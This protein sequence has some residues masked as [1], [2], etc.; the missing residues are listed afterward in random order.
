[1]AK[2][3]LKLSNLSKFY[4]G[5]Q[6]VVVG[7]NEVNLSFSRGEFVA[8]TGESGSGKSTLSHV[9][10]GILP[11]ESGEMFFAG[12]PTS[13]YDSADWEAYRRDNISFISQNYGILPGATVMENVVSALLLTGMEKLEAHTAVEA[14][15][16]QVEL[17]DLHKRRAAKLSSGQ[18]QRLSIARALAKPAPILIA[19]EPTGNLDPENSAKVIDLLTQAAQE[20]LVILVTHEFSEAEHCATRHIILQDGKV[21][22]DAPLGSPYE[23]EAFVRRPK[24]KKPVSHYVAR[25]QQRSRPVWSSFLA[26]FF[27]LTAFAV[28]AFLGTLIV[29]LDD[30]STRPYDNSIFKNGDEDRI[31]V[32]RQ[33]G[34]PL[35]E[36][37]YAALL[38]VS[39]VQQL[40]VYGYVTDHQYAYREGV[41]YDIIT[42]EE[43]RTDANQNEI[44][45]LYPSPKMRSSAPFMKTIP[46][47]PEGQTFLTAGRLPENMYEVVA[48]GDE[49][50]IGQE[51]TVYLSNTTYMPSDVY[52]EIKMTVVGVTDLEDGLYFHEDIGRV[53]MQIRL[54][55]TG[56]KGKSGWCFLPNSAVP[57]GEYLGPSTLI[58]EMNLK[59]FDNLKR[60]SKIAGL[61]PETI[62]GQWKFYNF[63]AVNDDQAEEYISLRAMGNDSDVYFLTHLWNYQS[64]SLTTS[65]AYAP[66][67]R[68]QI[69]SNSTVKYGPQE[70]NCFTFYPLGDS[71]IAE[72]G[73]IQPGQYLILYWANDTDVWAV[74]AESV[75][76]AGIYGHK[77]VKLTMDENGVPSGYGDSQIWT[78][79]LVG[80]NV[81]T[82]RSNYSTVTYTEIDGQVHEI[83]ENLETYLSSGF[84]HPSHAQNEA[85]RYWT[86]D[87]QRNYKSDDDLLSGFV[88]VSQ[89]DFDRL[90]WDGGC[91]Q[92]SLTIADY[93]Y[94]DRVLNAIQEM[95]YVAASPYQLGSVKQDE[96]LAQQR[97]QTLLICIAA[98]AA[99]VALQVIL[100]RAMFLGQMDSYRLLSNIGLSFK[101]AK[102]S[103]LWQILL[104]CITGQLINIGALALCNHLAVERIVHILR[105][106]HPLAIV[107]LIAVHFAVSMAAAWWI[108][109][110]LRKQ[111][112]A[113]VAR[114]NDLPVEDT[115]QEAEL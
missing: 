62:G 74:S 59:H 88:W 11:Y 87:R 3:I 34:L 63:N 115:E 1:M 35:T 53:W 41:D 99:I 52:M 96:G 27:A 21:V 84:V 26:L 107:S 50:M 36:E 8:I 104:F 93:A 61:L 57:E 68:N 101:M 83:V 18:K 37:D 102:R 54:K 78:V 97:E 29:N 10:G 92:A 19:D 25:L 82:I 91:E 13:H 69:I 47:L 110:T 112:Y 9:L 80:N 14:L 55:A 58:T 43:I 111:V 90:V 94:A 28:F 71:A 38:S 45:F 86:I 81:F 31:V 108:A 70:K 109:A 30:S 60:F 56:N 85:F 20:R 64:L 39:H 75:S 23:P 103:I 46:L 33:D 113:L 4:T 98:L 17:W 48:V 76:Y 77:A 44:L 49:S 105:Y 51:L 24:S 79:T 73:S 89:K 12:K 2:E 40:E 66:F 16:R 15:L 42:R 65:D 100:L 72:D 5:S 22:M 67:F 7:L 32:V 106:L 6:S 95:G 114:E